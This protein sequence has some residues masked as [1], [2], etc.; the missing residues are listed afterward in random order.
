[1]HKDQRAEAIF[2]LFKEHIK[3]G[4]DAG[5]TGKVFKAKAWLSEVKLNYF[6]VFGGFVPLS[7]SSLSDEMV[8][9]LHL[10]PGN[11]ASAKYVIYMLISPKSAPGKEQEDGMSLLWGSP[12]SVPGQKLIDFSLRYPNGEI[13]YPQKR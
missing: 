5:E 13:V 3:P 10:F 7:I 4:M 2:T 12:G 8:Y 9:S 6:A 11:E 1:M